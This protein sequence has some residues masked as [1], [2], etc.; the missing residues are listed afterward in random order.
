M[1]IKVKVPRDK[2]PSI[3]A[4]GFKLYLLKSSFYNSL[5][6]QLLEDR[7]NGRFD[8]LEKSQEEIE[9]T[10]A[11]YTDSIKACAVSYFTSRGVDV[12]EDDIFV[13]I[14][15]QWTAKTQAKDEN[16]WIILDEEEN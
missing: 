9:K 6:D 2:V 1:Y 12:L 13:K 8:A 7:K 16:Y 15:P 14:A 5:K 4:V 10:L 11:S 3:E